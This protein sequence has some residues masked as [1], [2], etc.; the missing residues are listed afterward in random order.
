MYILAAL[1]LASTLST[2][3]A[4]QDPTTY[5]KFLTDNKASAIVAD[6]LNSKISP[7][8]WP[9]S[10][11]AVIND[12]VPVPIFVACHYGPQPYPSPSSASNSTSARE[13]VSNIAYIA[14]DGYQPATRIEPQED[15]N[16]SWSLGLVWGGQ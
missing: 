5:A 16:Q 12:V 1:V 7:E 4:A 8:S 9:L 15:Y 6:D 13:Y 2:I 10:G 11:Y 3:E 14:G